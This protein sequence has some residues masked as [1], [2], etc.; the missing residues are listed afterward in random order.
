MNTRRI[1]LSGYRGS[2]KSTLGR[3]LAQRLGWDFVDLDEAVRQRFG[4]LTVA[5]IWTTFGQPAFRQTEAQ[6]AIEMLARENLVLALGGGTP[7]QE[8]AFQ[9]IRSC[10]DTIRIYLH[11]S[12]DELAKRIGADPISALQRPSLTAT[13]N[14]D[15]VSEVQQVLS[16][17]EATYR[18][19][20][21][22]TIDVTGQSVESLVDLL[23][24]SVRS[25]DSGQ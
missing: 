3:L 24:V 21:D 16:Q 10:S 25:S 12:A 14:S 7:M 1:I 15:A 4:G 5:E 8:R 23:W 20:A 19:L 22:Q 11:A 9:A 13:A 17:R 18:R 6:A 2:G